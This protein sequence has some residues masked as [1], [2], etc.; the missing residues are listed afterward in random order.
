[1]GSGWPKYFNDELP[2]SKAK[3]SFAAQANFT[4]SIEET[5]VEKRGIL[6]PGP[7][8]RSAKHEMGTSNCST[9]KLKFS[10]LR[11]KT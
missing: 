3:P 10:V 1:M 2:S 7:F 5:N 4:M 9:S 8:L 11:W 6:T